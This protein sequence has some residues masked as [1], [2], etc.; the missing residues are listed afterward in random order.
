MRPTTFLG[1]GLTTILGSV[2]AMFTAVIAT[3]ADAYVG[4][5]WEYLLVALAVTFVGFGILFGVALWAAKR[6]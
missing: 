3:K 6:D 4:Y 2:G 1:S 5:I